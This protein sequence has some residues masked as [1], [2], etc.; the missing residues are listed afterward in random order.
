MRE[1]CYFYPLSSLTEVRGIGETILKKIEEE[2]KAFVQPPILENV[3][4][5]KKLEKAKKE[6]EQDSP[7]TKEAEPQKTERVDINTASEEELQRLPG[8]GAVFAQKIIEA[9]PFYSLDELSKVSGIGP[10]TLE[11]IKEQGLAWIE[12]GVIPPQTEKEPGYPQTGPAALVETVS[13]SGYAAQDKSLKTPS[14]PFYASALAI[15]SGLIILIL[16]KKL[17]NS[18]DID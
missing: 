8:V 18:T 16:K 9:R 2:G 17:K 5:C 12:P 1:N 7:E 11:K 15:L 14:I 6:H 13:D 3:I 4:L 10:K